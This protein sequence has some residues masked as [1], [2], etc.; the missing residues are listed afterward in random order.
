M[1]VTIEDQKIIGTKLTVREGQI[2][3]LFV[4]SRL[5]TWSNELLCTLGPLKL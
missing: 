3:K 2:N 5:G 1:M 4:G